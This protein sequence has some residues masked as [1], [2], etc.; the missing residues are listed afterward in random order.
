MDYNRGKQ[1]NREEKAMLFRK[2]IDPQ[3]VYCVHS[4]P[5]DEER[6]T[7]LK[8]GV[9][10]KDSSCGKFSYDPLKRTPSRPKAPGLNALKDEDFSL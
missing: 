8:K 9:M 3:C 1:V 5:L 6:V 7:C 2:K 10:C 4:N